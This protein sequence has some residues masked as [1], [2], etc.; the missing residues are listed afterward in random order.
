[1]AGRQRRVGGRPRQT[2][3]IRS[4]WLNLTPER[5]V[6][7]WLWCHSCEIQSLKSTRWFPVFRREPEGRRSTA[8]QL[9]EPSS[10]STYLAQV[11]SVSLAKRFLVYS[12]EPAPSL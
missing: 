10:R 3:R 1:M 4:G 8:A 6:P 5:Y 7:P 12:P 9:V 2:P 11:P